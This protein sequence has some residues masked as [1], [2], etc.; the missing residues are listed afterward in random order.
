MSVS[1]Y[2][3]G[4]GWVIVDD[5]SRVELS[6]HADHGVAMKHAQHINA[7]IATMAMG[8]VGLTQSVTAGDAQRGCT[9]A[10]GFAVEAIGCPV[11]DV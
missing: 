10:R 6:K 5:D 11:H 4:D 8:T 3:H 7:K 9:C 2:P 1:V